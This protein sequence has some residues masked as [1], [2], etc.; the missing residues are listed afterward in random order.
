[1]LN[2]TA[3]SSVIK[4]KSHAQDP[5]GI[6]TFNYYVSKLV[7]VHLIKYVD[8][9]QSKGFICFLSWIEHMYD[10]METSNN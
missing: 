10:K 6:H 9:S 7:V 5:I 1:M 3:V 8:R 2:E 4:W